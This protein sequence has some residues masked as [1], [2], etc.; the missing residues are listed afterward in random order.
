[1]TRV[2]LASASPRRKML[3]ESI[4]LEVVVEPGDVDESILAKESAAT[5]VKRLSLAKA[6]TGASRHKNDRCL[7]I[8]AD[9]VVVL[10]DEI[11]GKPAD[12]NHAF[13]MLTRLVNRTH[14]VLTGVCVINGSESRVEQFVVS[15]MVS[16]GQC[17]VESIL[18]YIASGEPFDKAGAY[19]IQGIGGKFVRKIEGSYSNVVGLPLYETWQVLEAMMAMPENG[20][21]CA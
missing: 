14:E 21:V 3:L 1:M 10:D 11:L 16:F 8:G 6:R 9:T 20:F 12:K 4:G 7:V 15:T 5:Y 18:D 2:I 17:K 19:A 13:S